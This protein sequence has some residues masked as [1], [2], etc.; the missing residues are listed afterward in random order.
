MNQDCDFIIKDGWLT[1]YFGTSEEI[2]IPEGV[3]RIDNWVFIKNHHMK[4]RRII[5]P[6]TLEEILPANFAELVW[7][8]EI[9]IPRSVKRIGE[10][11][12]YNCK[13]LKNVKIENGST[14]VDYGAFERTP[15]KIDML[16]TYGMFLVGDCLLDSFHR[17]KE[18]SIPPHIKVICEKA[19]EGSQLTNIIIPEGVEV[20]GEAAFR[21]SNI[22]HI[23]L[24]NSIKRIGDEAFSDCRHLKAITI[25]MSITH[26][27]GNAFEWLPNCVLTV[28]NPDCNIWFGAYQKPDKDDNTS[29]RKFFVKEL[30]APKGSLAIRNAQVCGVPYT[31]LS[32]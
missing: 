32:L 12:F 31:E 29:F 17:L 10:L 26:V 9:R 23:L 16:R 7:L 15:W 18:I 4:I 2:I 22:E 28:L 24:P 25:P 13:N 27:D 14:K 6:E 21:R 20:I 11:A 3:T 30:R 19:F 1:D 8:E 5:L